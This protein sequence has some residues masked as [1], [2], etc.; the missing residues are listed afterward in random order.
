MTSDKGERTMARAIV[1]TTAQGD[2][3]RALYH[4]IVMEASDLNRSALE[5]LWNRGM[6]IKNE[7]GT[8]R[9][10]SFGRT[11]YKSL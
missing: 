10:S 1:I 11:I 5:G 9:I 7:D 3:L 4:N 8:Y 2:M 6:A